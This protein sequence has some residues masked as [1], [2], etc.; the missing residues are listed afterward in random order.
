MNT[1][2][3]F[4]FV[5]LNFAVSWLNAWSCGCSWKTTKGTGFPHFMNWC[6]AVMSACGFT[7]VYMV[8]LGVIGIATGKLPPD[9]AQAFF[10]LGYLVIILPVLGSGIAITIQSWVNFSK[11]RSVGNGLTAGYNT[12]AQG[13]N[14]YRA[15]KD[16]PDAIGNV[17]DFFMPKK[18][19]SGKD[20]GAGFLVILL[21]LVT[22]FGGCLTTY[23]IIKKTS[24]A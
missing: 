3:L 4:F 24:E 18:K 16:V 7:W 23:M 12:L 19:S 10:S 9:A 21:V 6:G 1:L 14:T 22:V 11:N 5:I 20:G 2:V 13:Y 15:V 17:M 8:I